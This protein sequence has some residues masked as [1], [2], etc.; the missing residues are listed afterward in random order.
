MHIHLNMLVMHLWRKKLKYLYLFCCIQF[1]QTKKIMLIWRASPMYVSTREK[2]NQDLFVCYM[3]ILVHGKFIL[4]C[5]LPNSITER[6]S[7]FIYQEFYF[8]KDGLIEWK[9]KCGL[10]WATGLNMG[11]TCRLDG[12]P[13]DS[14]PPLDGPLPWALLPNK[15]MKIE[16]QWFGPTR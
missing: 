5:R 11:W 14:A 13:R 15:R 8:K 7:S 2:K 10:N 1:Q 3:L 6:M 16:E 9:K 12:P 4:A